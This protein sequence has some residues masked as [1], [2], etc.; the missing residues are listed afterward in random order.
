MVRMCGPYPSQF[1]RTNNPGLLHATLI[2]SGSL[3]NKLAKKLVLASIST[4]PDIL[5]PFLKQASITLDLKPVSKWLIG[6]QFLNEVC[7]HATSR[8]IPSEGKGRTEE[9]YSVSA[10]YCLCI[11]QVSITF[12]FTSDT[13]TQLYD[14]LPAVCEL[15]GTGPSRLTHVDAAV[16]VTIPSITT[17]AMLSQWIQVTR[18]WVQLDRDT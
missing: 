11:A 18:G 1:Y 4:C 16:S 5:L 15:V 2:L 12:N 8:E 10:W 6:T 9:L 7:T 17:R 14:Q 13:T 3:E